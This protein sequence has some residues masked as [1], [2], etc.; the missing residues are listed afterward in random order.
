ME[1]TL[2]CAKPAPGCE[3]AAND[4]VVAEAYGGNHLHPSRG[5]I[6]VFN[7]PPAAA[8]KCGTGGIF[9]KRLIGLPGETV[10]EDGQGFIFVDGKKFE[11]S[12]VRVAARRA[13]GYTFNQTWH[14]PNGEYFFM[15]DNRPVSCDSRE[16]GSVPR[17]NIIG[18]V[19][20]IKRPG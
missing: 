18:K 13:D 8:L 19:V 3:A 9:V 7:T 14:V 6:I 20:E 4:R 17:A 2:H 10:H 5:D 1:P 15:G 16:W 11:E 12:Y